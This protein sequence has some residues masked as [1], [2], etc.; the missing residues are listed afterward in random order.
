MSFTTILGSKYHLPSPHPSLLC[1]HQASI[2]VASSSMPMS[3]PAGPSRCQQ[4]RQTRA[5]T[6]GKTH[7]LRPIRH[8]FAPSPP[9]HS[10][11]VW[12]Q[13]VALYPS[14]STD[15]NGN[16]ETVWHQ[17]RGEQRAKMVT[18]ATTE[19]GVPDDNDGSEGVKRRPWWWQEAGM[20]HNNQP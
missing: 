20:K 9:Q 4:H 5:P 13:D 8:F 15:N 7:H 16:N 1:C 19:V 3:L 12:L 10:A 18:T 17:R 11:C 14:V 2:T 6:G